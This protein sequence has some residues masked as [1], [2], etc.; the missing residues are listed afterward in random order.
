MVCVFHV[1]TGVCALCCSTLTLHC[2]DQVPTNKAEAAFEFMK[3]WI[4]DTDYPTYDKNCVSPPLN[5]VSPHAQHAKAE[6][7]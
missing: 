4:E 3:S 1:Y 5:T 6:K 7:N 2:Y